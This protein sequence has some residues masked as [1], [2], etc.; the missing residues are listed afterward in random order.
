MKHIK[1]Y[2][3]FLESTAAAE[4]TTKPA[5]TKTPVKVPTKPEKPIKPEEPIGIP[6]ISPERKGV[7][8]KDVVNRF[9][10]E[11][12]EQGESIKKYLDK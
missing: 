11:M 6:S 9:L 8:E 10:E 3:M 12:D 7:T 2:K 1:K 4:P 5:P